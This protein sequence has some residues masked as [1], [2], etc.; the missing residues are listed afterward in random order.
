MT[1]SFKK[2][3]ISIQ[4]IGKQRFWLG[5]VLGVFSAVILSLGFNYFR[6]LS[7]FFTAISADLLIF[8]EFE[9]QFYDYFFSSLATVLGLSISISIWMSNNNHIRRKDKIYKQLSR[10]NIFFT[11]WVLL[12]MVARFGFIVTLILHGTSGFDNQL[13]LLEEYWLLLVLLPMV[14]FAQNWFIV[15][16]IYRSS[17]WILLSF[18]IGVLLT[19]AL[20]ITTSMDQDILNNAYYKRFELDY[21]YVDQQIKKA[22]IDY[23]I[24]F[25][26][27]TIKTLKKWHTQRSTEQVVCLKSAF[28]KNKKV[29]LDSIILQKI[30]IKNFKENGSY[31]RRNSID[32][33]P[34]ALPKDVLK[35][36][37]FFDINSN[38]SK[39]LIEI[40]KEQIEL[41]T[42]PEIDWQEYDK[43][44]DTEI[45][46]S[47]GMKRTIPKQIYAQL[48]KVRDSL[49]T[50][51][52][53]HE[54][55]KDLPE[56]IQRNDN[57]NLP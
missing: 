27:N 38:E 54:I 1:R 51:K 35:Q 15:R 19:F 13:N 33:W 18:L 34:Y 43:H 49:R 2:Q 42:T 26:K 17:T 36:L 50:S 5:I 12:M 41:V 23:G 11:F 22:K 45:R 57:S 30:V 47:F 44:T 28:S 14:V 3:K 10:A 25:E 9:I 20:K 24:T 16:L 8:E 52:K 56:V 39:E 32:N 29:S 53:Y 37:E 40:I 7:R 48:D 31:F 4:N 6:E 46:K 55:S 21:L